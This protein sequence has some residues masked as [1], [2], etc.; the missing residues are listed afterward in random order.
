MGRV[1][2]PRPFVDVYDCESDVHYEGTRCV[3]CQCKEVLEAHCFY[4][5]AAHVERKVDHG[6]VGSVV[7]PDLRACDWR[8]SVSFFCL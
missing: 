4:A 1:T 3:C 7:E 8:W 5:V 2:V 6:E